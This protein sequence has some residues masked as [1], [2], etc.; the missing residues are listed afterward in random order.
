MNQQ[1]LQGKLLSPAGFGLVLLCFFLPFVAVSCGPADEQATAT[2]TGLAMV[3]GTQ[4]EITGPNLNPDDVATI[5]ALVSDQYDLEPMALFAAIVVMAAMAS[6]LIKRVRTR[7]I[8]GISLATA[9]FVLLTGAVLRSTARLEGM[10]VAEL[11]D[12]DLVTT[13]RVAS[14]RYGYW[15]AAALLVALVAWHVFNLLRTPREPA[16]EAASPVEQPHEADDGLFFRD[17]P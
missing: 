17:D 7:H 10:R 6:A 4:P 3:T 13:D 16:P 9:A 11:I 12:L 2:W 1:T 5:H 14:V 8:V 15:L